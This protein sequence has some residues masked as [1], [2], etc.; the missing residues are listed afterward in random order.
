MGNLWIGTEDAGLNYFNSQEKSIIPVS[1]HLEHY[2]VH[3]L[4]V[5]DDELYV[6]YILVDSIFIILI[7]ER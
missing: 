4:C 7:L 1:A 5:I 2:N 6:G 3:G